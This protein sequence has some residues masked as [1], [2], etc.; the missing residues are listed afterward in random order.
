MTRTS[1]HRRRLATALA[2]VLAVPLAV[3][4]EA[5]A[6]TPLQVECLD[7]FTTAGGLPGLVA[8]DLPSASHPDT[9][10]VVYDFGRG[11]ETIGSDF[12]FYY[13][14][15][16]GLFAI[17][18]A[19]VATAFKLKGQFEVPAIT[20][21]HRFQIQ[22][23]YDVN[24]NGWYTG[25]QCQTQLDVAPYSPTTVVG[26][27]KRKVNGGV[28]N[29]PSSKASPT[30]ELN[31]GAGLAPLSPVT[32]TMPLP[33]ATIVGASTTPPDT[34]PTPQARATNEPSAS[35]TTGVP[36][37]AQGPVAV[38]IPTIAVPTSIKAKK[39]AQARRPVRKT[40]VKR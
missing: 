18:R 40:T 14:T 8:V 17:P 26:N 31:S 32:T 28:V 27:Q 2:I 25:Y 36:T 12:R 5:R 10:R 11:T 9:V 33:K 34:A 22:I 1:A 30:A 6:D 13:W 39:S 7:L 35:T 29:Q 4:G 23:A 38:T 16:T 19:T 15:P 3:A 21:Q 37:E 20:G 24:R